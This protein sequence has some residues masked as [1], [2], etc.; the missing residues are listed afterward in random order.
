MNKFA[1]TIVSLIMALTYGILIEMLCKVVELLGYQT[2]VALVAAVG[3]FA[4]VPLGLRLVDWFFKPSNK[5]KSK[6]AVKQRAKSKLDD[7]GGVEGD[8]EPKTSM[9]TLE[10]ME[11]KFKK[12]RDD[13]PDLNFMGV[14]IE[15]MKALARTQKVFD[16][17]TTDS[18]LRARKGTEVSPETLNLTIESARE[19]FGKTV[20]EMRQNFSDIYNLLLIAG[21]KN[22]NARRADVNI[23]ALTLEVNS[24][25]A[26]LQRLRELSEQVILYINHADMAGENVGI[27]TEI[28]VLKQINAR[29]Y[30]AR[31]GE[32]RAEAPR[33]RRIIK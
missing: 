27:D 11:R 1:K 13:N 8:P 15:Q 24:N 28:E 20:E 29:R 14:I 2:L 12:W 30:G 3:I 17:I 22:G 10:Q 32:L 33:V 6:K 25:H 21:V 16:E 19:A 9:R 5:K 18:M 31:V 26:K 7:A 23:E 4:S